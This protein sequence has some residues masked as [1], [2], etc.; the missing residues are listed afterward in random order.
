MKMRIALLACCCLAIAIAWRDAALKPAD[1][2]D[3][4]ARISTVERFSET[5]PDLSAPTM[6]HDDNVAFDDELRGYAA[7]KY[8]YLF[9]GT[10]MNNVSIAEVNA[11]LF[12]REA[13]CRTLEADPL[14]I[15]L[16]ETLQGILHPSDF[17][18]YEVL[19]NSDAEQHRTTEY[20][21]GID[22]FSPLNSDQERA[23]LETRLRLKGT[24]ETRIHDIQGIDENH[25]SAARLQALADY[26]TYLLTEMQS[27]LS[28][29][30]F[31]LL[32]SYENTEFDA[33]R[34]RLLQRS[35]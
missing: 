19:K 14:C 8:R 18:R 9:A 6:T 15:R 26:K 10:P 29:E 20:A 7:Y 33:E 34:E 30:Q 21:S 31:T 11:L 25:S 2:G 12:H 24:Y 4:H 28:E 1:H 23:L 13:S 17:A 5:K 32:S 3:M 27:L 16:D 35:N 22:H